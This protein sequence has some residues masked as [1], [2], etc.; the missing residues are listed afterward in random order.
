[1][2]VR[3]ESQVSVQNR[4]DVFEEDDDEEDDDSSTAVW[5]QVGEEEWEMDPAANISPARQ[6]QLMELFGE[7]GI[8]DTQEEEMEEVDGGDETTH[9]RA[10]SSGS[11]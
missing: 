8:P 10:R 9:G 11:Q 3:Y 1:M 6:L 4:F 7:A 5:K 2:E